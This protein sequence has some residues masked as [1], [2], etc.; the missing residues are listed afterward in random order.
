MD[1]LASRGV[2]VI[3]TRKI[4]CALSIDCSYKNEKGEL[5]LTDKG[6]LSKVGAKLFGEE[7]LKQVELIRQVVGDNYRQANYQ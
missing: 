7:L 1:Y 6:H 4:F 5:L 2:N 3:N